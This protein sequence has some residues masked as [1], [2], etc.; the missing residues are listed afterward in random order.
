[1]SIQSGLVTICS[2]SRHR[3]SRLKY[4]YVVPVHLLK[5][6]PFFRYVVFVFRRIMKV[7]THMHEFLQRPDVMTALEGDTTALVQPEAEAIERSAASLPADAT[8]PRGEVLPRVPSN[9]K[10]DDGESSQVMC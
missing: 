3:S 4:L 6:C 7:L 9:P 8:M 5:N 2:E 1:M 10:F